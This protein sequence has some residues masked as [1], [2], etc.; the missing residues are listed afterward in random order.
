MENNLN[1]SQK[2]IVELSQ[3]LENYEKIQAK[4]FALSRYY[5]SNQW[6]KDLEDDEAGKLPHDL[7]RGV[8]S[9][10]AVYNLIKDHQDLIKRMA[11]CIAEH[12]TN[13]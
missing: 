13:D 2:A 9:E 5:G 7:K 3:A 6:R 12:L 8:L 11:C 1:E 10:D 4:Y